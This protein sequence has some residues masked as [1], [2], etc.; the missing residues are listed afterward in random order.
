MAELNRDFLSNRY[1][2]LL[3]TR[4]FGISASRAGTKAGAWHPTWLEVAHSGN[5]R[6]LRFCCRFFSMAGVMRRSGSALVFIV[7]GVLALGLVQCEQPRRSTPP[8][9]TSS[10]VVTQL[11][12]QTA[13][14]VPQA[15][16]VPAPSA[17][18]PPPFAHP[19]ANTE[20]CPE[21]MVRVTGAYCPGVIQTCEEYHEEYLQSKR[22]GTVSER[23]LKFKEPSRCVVEQRKNLDFCMDRYE[24]PNQVGEKPWV[25]TSWRQAQLMCREQGKRLCSEDEYNF[26]CEG[27]EMLPYVTGYVRDATLCTIDREYHRPNH[28]MRLL[29]Y[30]RC[31][32]DESCR[33]EFERLDQRHAIGSK[34]SCVSWAGVVDLNGN[35]NEWVRRPHKEPPNRSGLKGG[36]WGPVRNRCR[37]TVAFHKEFDYGYEAGFRCCKGLGTESPDP[38]YEAERFKVSP[39]QLADRKAKQEE[40][41]KRSQSKTEPAGE[42][43]SSQSSEPSRSESSAAKER[44]NSAAGAAAPAA[45]PGSAVE[46]VVTPVPAPS[47]SIAGSTPTPSSTPVP[48]PA[49]RHAPEPRPLVPTAPSVQPTPRRDSPTPGNAPPSSASA[50]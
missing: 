36:W 18:A 16:A 22:D 43:P 12:A 13:S 11:P 10:K 25:L 6:T 15:K 46:P 48:P 42:P 21:G 50:R 24:Y 5:R 4:F 1:A 31:L 19:P 30:Q 40:A 37:P 17:S 38:R 20:G 28:E 39:E 8:A 47:D 29:T 23:C 44:G 14:A 41:A 7:M 49:S 3:I 27:P 2:S 34:L 9:A 32:D 35:V 33:T 45:A 26:A